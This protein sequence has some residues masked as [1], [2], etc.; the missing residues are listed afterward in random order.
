MKKQK[1]KPKQGV[2]VRSIPEKKDSVAAVNASMGKDELTG[3]NH[4]ELSYLAA[5]FL[6]ENLKRGIHQRLDTDPNFQ[7]NMREYLYCAYELIKQ[8]RQFLEE[9]AEINRHLDEIVVSPKEIKERQVPTALK[10]RFGTMRELSYGEA[11]EAIRCL[12]RSKKDKTAESLQKRAMTQVK[13]RLDENKG[14]QSIP[15]ENRVSLRN[16]MGLIEEL[17][18]WDKESKRHKEQN[19][20]TVNFESRTVDQETIAGIVPKSPE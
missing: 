15:L 7:L 13:K 11:K 3:I 16:L 10:A 9:Q 19:S 18:N 12:C 4:I 8:S 20:G 6:P 5:H 2:G 1:N 14:K 17:R